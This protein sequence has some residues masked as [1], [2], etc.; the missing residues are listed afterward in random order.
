M[1]AVLAMTERIKP[2]LRG[3]RAAEALEELEREHANIQT[4]LRWAIAQGQAGSESALRICTA[5]WSFWKQRGHLRE[6]EHWLRE[7]IA[8]GEEE[9][10]FLGNGYLLLGHTVSDQRAG[11]T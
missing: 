4:A 2:E 3:D 11:W 5:V 9:S 8:A 1:T 6:A 10:L 7:A